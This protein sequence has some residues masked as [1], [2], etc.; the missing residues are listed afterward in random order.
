MF[1]KIEITPVSMLF[2]LIT[3]TK[4]EIILLNRLLKLLQQMYS[5]K[6]YKLNLYR[7]I[8]GPSLMEATTLMTRHDRENL[9]LH[10]SRKFKELCTVNIIASKTVVFLH[11]YELIKKLFIHHADSFS[12]RPKD[13]WLVHHLSKGKGNKYCE[14]TKNI[15]DVGKIFFFFEILKLV[16]KIYLMMSL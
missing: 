3:I 9:F 7:I 11:S 6:F 14:D 4:Q 2:L 12:N 5:L 10:W 8:S 15:T 1:S 13:R 16:F